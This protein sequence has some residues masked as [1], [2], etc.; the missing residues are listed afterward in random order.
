M[1][2]KRCSPIKERVKLLDFRQQLSAYDKFFY[3]GNVND[4]KTNTR[5]NFIRR[6]SLS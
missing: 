6:V 3:F 5:Q 2:E 4:L 1:S